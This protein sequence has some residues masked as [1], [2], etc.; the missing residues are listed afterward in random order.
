MIEKV[1]ILLLRHLLQKL[2][3]IALK[4]IM[5]FW[6]NK[7]LIKRIRANAKESHWLPTIIISLTTIWLI[8]TFSSLTEIL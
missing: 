6:T 7:P 3:K 5:S 8:F 2:L 1:K 4:G